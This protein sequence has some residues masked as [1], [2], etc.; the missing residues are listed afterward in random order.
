MVR[1]TVFWIRSAR[2]LCV[3]CTVRWTLGV[4][5]ELYSVVSGPLSVFHNLF[6][7]GTEE[8]A[9]CWRRFL[10]QLCPLVVGNI[11]VW[12]RIHFTSY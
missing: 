2:F 6:L 9:T 4:I 7:L 12:H 5:L 3:H 8:L 1:P 11:R 10:A